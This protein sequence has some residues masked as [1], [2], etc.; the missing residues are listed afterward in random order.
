VTWNLTNSTEL[1]DGVVRW[2]SF[3][4]GPPAPHG[5]W[6]AQRVPNQ[7]LTWIDDAGHLL[8]EDALAQLIERLTA[9]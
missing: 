3:G 6:I 4:E 7:G 2:D 9:S 5:H 1:A 8:P